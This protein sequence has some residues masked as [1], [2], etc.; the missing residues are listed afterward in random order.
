MKNTNLAQNENNAL[1]TTGYLKNLACELI[2][3]W[4]LDGWVFGWN[5]NKTRIGVCR[6]KSKRIE[7]AIFRFENTVNSDLHLFIDT[8]KHEIAHALAGP[9]AGHGPVW[10]KWAV[11]VGAVPK[12]CKRLKAKD[13][14]KGAKWLLVDGSDNDKVVKSY[15]QQPSA[16]MFAEVGMLMV[17]GR[18]QSLGKLRFVKV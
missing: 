15:Y 14:S 8:V 5:T 11:K 9:R 1:I 3:Q 2:A 6:H 17:K 7:L 10:K 13:P 12:A 16:K 4:G 18:P